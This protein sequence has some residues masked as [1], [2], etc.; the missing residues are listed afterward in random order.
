MAP[1]AALSPTGTND[2]AATM[3]FESLRPLWI[4]PATAADFIELS[5]GAQG[6]FV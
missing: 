3:P 6:I 5:E 1:A 2:A 4:P